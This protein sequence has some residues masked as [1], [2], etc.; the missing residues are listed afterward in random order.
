M[1]TNMKSTHVT[2]VAWE[3]K[4]KNAH[5]ARKQQNEKKHDR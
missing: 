3:V 2:K 5:S 1:K 4:Q